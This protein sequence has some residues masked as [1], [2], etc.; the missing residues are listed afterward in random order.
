MKSREFRRL[1]LVGLVLAGL[2]SVVPAAFAAASGADRLRESG[3]AQMEGL[4][5]HYIDF[6]GATPA[7]TDYGDG[8]YSLSI[9]LDAATRERMLAAVDE[10]GA[11]DKRAPVSLTFLAAGQSLSAPSDPTDLSHAAL[12]STN[13]VYNYWV[14]VVN[15]GT[16]N[17]TKAT[18]FKLSGTGLTFNRS[19]SIPYNANGIWVA[20]YNPA[21]SVRNPGFY[22]YVG[23]VSGFG[24]FTTHTLAVNP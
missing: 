12:S 15:L 5:Q 9:T 4:L 3:A 2:L 21:A 1:L 7:F 20:W 13:L 8:L 17:V 22:T 24:T 11:T 19:F 16:Q 18:S 10:D 6:N 14:V 23:G